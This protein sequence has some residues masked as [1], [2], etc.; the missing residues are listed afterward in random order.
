MWRRP[1]HRMGRAQ[2]RIST[3]RRRGGPVERNPFPI[4]TARLPTGL[5]ESAGPALAAEAVPAELRPLLTGGDP[6]RELGHELRRQMEAAEEPPLALRRLESALLERDA[7]SAA[8]LDEDTELR[9]LATQVDA[10]RRPLIQALLDGRPVTA[11]QRRQLLAPWSAPLMVQ[12][13][14]CE[15]LPGDPGACPA[16]ERSLRLLLMLLVL[17]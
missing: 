5:E 1:G 16:E 14:V 6:R 15:Q 12:Q 3:H 13:L 11:E 2:G 17:M 10:V 9:Q 7:G 8:A 4:R